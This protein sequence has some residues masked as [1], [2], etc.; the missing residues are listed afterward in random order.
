LTSTLT[1]FS[2][3]D[4]QVTD[5]SKQFPDILGKDLETMLKEQEDY[6]ADQFFERSGPLSDGAFDSNMLNH[7]KTTEECCNELK[8]LWARYC[9]EPILGR[10]AMKLGLLGEVTLT[11]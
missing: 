5:R 9:E 11:G 3:F 6:K 10:E 7:A 2:D 1:A 8:G 4:I